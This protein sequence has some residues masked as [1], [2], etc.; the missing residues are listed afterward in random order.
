MDMLL[1]IGMTL[2]PFQ[3]LLT[4]HVYDFSHTKDELE[5]EEGDIFDWPSYLAETE[6]IGVP[7]SL[8]KHVGPFLFLKSGLYYSSY[9]ALFSNRAI[10]S[11]MFSNMHMLDVKDVKRLLGSMKMA[12]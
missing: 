5:E 3:F 7:A 1:F 10:M 8:F 6:S 4:L 12:Y 11:N 2:I 9:L